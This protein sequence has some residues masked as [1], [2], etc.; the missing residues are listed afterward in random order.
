MG[1]SHPDISLQA[2][3]G[4]YSLPKLLGEVDAA[5]LACRSRFDDLFSLAGNIRK[6]EFTGPSGGGIPAGT[7]VDLAHLMGAIPGIINLRLFS[8][9]IERMEVRDPAGGPNR[10]AFGRV[11][12]L[13]DAC[14]IRAQPVWRNAEEVP[15]DC[16]PTAYPSSVENPHATLPSWGN[17]P[18]V[19]EEIFSIHQLDE[20]EKPRWPSVS[21][22]PAT[23][24]HWVRPNA[25]ADYEHPAM[26]VYTPEVHSPAGVFIRGQ[27]A[28]DVRDGLVA[29]GAEPLGP[30]LGVQ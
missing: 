21:L 4:R 28:N 22:N 25:Q 11:Y 8:E 1:A 18:P 20:S 23:D 5:L 12:T 16:R 30:H 26:V 6:V 24:L 14:V 7:Y 27:A 10:L 13:A 19:G 29:A 17:A 9:D 15:P 3:S 2:S